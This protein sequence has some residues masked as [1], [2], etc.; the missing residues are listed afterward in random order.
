[1]TTRT[2]Q[3]IAVFQHAFSLGGVDG[4]LPAGSYLIETEE[5]RIDAL[6]FV[7]Y[8]RIATTITLPMIGADSRKRQ[9]VTI[10]PDDITAARARDDAHP[11]T[12]LDTDKAR[13]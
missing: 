7:A 4:D 3:T 13:S 9:V 2:T 11:Q 1:M 10:D 12:A 6:S 8:R 5:E